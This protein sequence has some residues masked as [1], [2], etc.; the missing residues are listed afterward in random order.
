MSR[1]LR[2][3]LLRTIRTALRSTIVFCA[4]IETVGV[5]S[6]VIFALL[7]E[8]AIAGDVVPVSVTITFAMS[9]LL[10]V[11][12]CAFVVNAY[13]FDVVIRFPSTFP[14]IAFTIRKL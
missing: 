5:E 11:V 9:G 4:V 2:R 1:I 14:D 3:V 12:H 8:F 6:T 13:E 10:S 7:T